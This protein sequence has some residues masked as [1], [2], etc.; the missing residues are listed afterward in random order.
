[1]DIINSL[2]DYVSPTYTKK[3]KNII[4][5]IPFEKFKKILSL[6]TGQNPIDYINFTMF[7]IWK[8][9]KEI[10]IEPTT[11]YTSFEESNVYQVLYYDTQ[12]E[13]YLAQ[14]YETTD[15]YNTIIE[16][17]NKYIFFPFMLSFKDE[18][19]GHATLLIVDKEDKS[20]RFFDPN[21][22]NGCIRSEI[23]DK[24]FKTYIDIFNICHSE[25]YT[26]FNQE[27]W[28]YGNHNNYRLNISTLQGGEIEAGHCMIFTLLIAHLLT[29]RK[30]NIND[31][32]FQLNKLDKKELF[33]MIMGYTEM[34]AINIKLL[35]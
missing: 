16:N 31:I 25:T 1:M 7:M 13:S 18:K 23:T 6:Y 21:G 22:F 14:M 2:K 3:S 19:I 28:L 24:L 5:R 10:N 35:Y 8:D 17:E 34:A 15:F 4:S 30:E 12:N 33:D 27:D 11:S 20:V 29:I 9:K 26:Y 32:I